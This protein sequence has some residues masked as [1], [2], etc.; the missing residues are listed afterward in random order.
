[1]QCAL[2]EAIPWLIGRDIR[3][4]RSLIRAC[5]EFLPDHP[6]AAAALEC[7]LLEAYV[8][9]RGQTLSQWLGGRLPSVETDLTLSLGSPSSLFSQARAAASRT[10]FRRFKVKLGRDSSR[11][12]AE[13]VRAVHRAVP[14]A[15]LVADGN[16]GMRL[17]GALE[18][19]RL[20]E[21][22][23]IRLVFLEQPFPKGDWESMRRFR[24]RC[25]T[26]LFAD[27]SALTS[28]DA[29]RLFESGAAGGVVVK[30]A[31]SGLWGALEIIRVAKRFGKRLAI[32]CME[33]SKGGLSA[34]V[35]LACGTG[36][37]EWVDLD[38]L[39]LLEP[40]RLPC[41]F[42]IKGPVLSVK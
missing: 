1:M 14:R 19:V 2:N 9:S 6:T 35:H 4:C 20:L 34:S 37:F 13:R 12:N 22:A 36:A 15:E 30:L 11:K 18:F 31:K 41:A 17:E 25:A 10:G 33:E 7:A 29:R 42:G 26:P 8:R 39:F 21:R 40:S 32:G 3:R 24:R 16:Q 5:W 27:K 28:G 38:S 23:C